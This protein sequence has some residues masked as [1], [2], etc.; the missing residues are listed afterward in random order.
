MR[1]PA[2]RAR[3][4]C[5]WRCGSPTRKVEVAPGKVGEILV[6][7]RNLMQG[8]WGDP[9]IPPFSTAGSALAISPYQDPEGFY[10]VV[11]RF[12]GHDH[13]RR[14]EHLQTEL[15][16]CWPTARYR[17]SRR[18]PGGTMRA[19]AG[20]GGGHW[21]A[22]RDL[23]WMP[24]ACLA[25]FEGRLARFKHPRRVV[26]ANQL[27]KTALGKVQKADLRAGLRSATTRGA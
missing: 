25:L 3:P 10:Y 15:E 26:F 1:K 14:R 5:T 13:L 22:G 27:P 4:A 2:A 18:D 17:R 20:G 9:P 16:T 11:G 21:C 8:Y 24:Q 19:G 6:R 23:P 12:Q 7:G